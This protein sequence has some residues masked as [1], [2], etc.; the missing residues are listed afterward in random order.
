MRGCEGFCEW[1]V[2]AAFLTKATSCVLL[3][4]LSH[5]FTSLFHVVEG[6]AGLVWRD[7]ERRDDT[8]PSWEGQR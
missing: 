6:C 8:D 7:V 4:R 2:C 3:R 1:V 5:S